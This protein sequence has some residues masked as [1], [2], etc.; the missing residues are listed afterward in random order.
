MNSQENNALDRLMDDEICTVILNNGIQREARWSQANW[1]FF[2]TN[3][4][5]PTM[6]VLENIKE[7]WPASAKF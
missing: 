3:T 2:R 4:D 6:I 7:W 1:C 5:K